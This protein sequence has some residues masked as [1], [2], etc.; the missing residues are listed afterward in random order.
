MNWAISYLT[1][2]TLTIECLSYWRSCL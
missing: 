1:H 2:L